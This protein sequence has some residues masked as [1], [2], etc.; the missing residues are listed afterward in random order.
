MESNEKDFF[1]FSGTRLQDF[2][3]SDVDKVHYP[4]RE[5]G[6]STSLPIPIDSS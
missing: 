1:F 4:D 6:G 5:S 2:R 3:S